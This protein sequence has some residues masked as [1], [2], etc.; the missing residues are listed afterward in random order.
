[1]NYAHQSGS[2]TAH[3]S[4]SLDAEHSERNASSAALKDSGRS[5]G[6]MCR[7]ASMTTRCMCDRCPT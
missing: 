4:T 3:F 7:L 5:T 2:Q 1:M 6:S